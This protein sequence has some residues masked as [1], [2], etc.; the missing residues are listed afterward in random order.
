M[1]EIE[2]N[3]A[4]QSRKLKQKDKTLVQK[5]FLEGKRDEEKSSQVKNQRK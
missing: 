3:R 4:T 1:V 2:V 5:I